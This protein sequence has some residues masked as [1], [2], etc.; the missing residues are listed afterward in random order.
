MAAAPLAAQPATV[1]FVTQFL[2]LFYSLA[3]LVTPGKR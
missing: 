1:L 3:Y 2:P